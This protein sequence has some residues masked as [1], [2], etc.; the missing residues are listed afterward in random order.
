MIIHASQ[1]IR[2]ESLVE[3]VPFE[4]R[5]WNFQFGSGIISYYKKKKKLPPLRQNGRHTKHTTGRV[6]ARE[7]LMFENWEREKDEERISFWETL[8]LVY[9]NALHFWQ[10]AIYRRRPWNVSEISPLRFLYFFTPRLKCSQR[11]ELY[12]RVYSLPWPLLCLSFLL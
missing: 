8:R 9:I 7:Y 11:R 5:M 1:L 12:I 4:N 2:N 10:R 6:Y 3:S